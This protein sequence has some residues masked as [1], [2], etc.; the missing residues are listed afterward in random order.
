MKSHSI[1][2]VKVAKSIAAINRNDWDSVFP[3]I[4]ESYNFF[5]TI[6]ETM[7]HQFKPYYISIFKEERII[8]VAPCFIMDYPL[9]TTVEGRLKRVLARIRNIAPKL[10]QW[11]VLICGCTAAEGRIG[12]KDIIDQRIPQI[13]IKKMY[14]IARKEKARLIAFKD[15]SQEYSEFFAPLIKSGFHKMQSYP[16]VELNIRFRSFEDYLA[17]L[18]RITRKGLYRKFREVEEQVKIE[19]EVRPDLAEF[20]DKAYELYLNTLNKSKVQFERLSKEFFRR[21]SIN[22]PEEVKYFLWRING[23]LVAF[24]LCLVKGDVLVDEYIGLDYAVAYKY[25]LYYVT[26]RDILIWCI[27][28]GIRRYESGALNYDPK[29][30]LDFKFL[31]QYIY[32]KH[33]SFFMNLL[34][35]LLCLIIKPENFD[36]VLK[37]M[38]KSKE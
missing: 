1:F 7:L 24:D 11:R 17:S 22:M 31:P 5:K 28:H 14:S 19:M 15:F 10:L 30:R 3:S 23:E 38:E 18:S 13:L 6:D 16:S 29:K 35:G 9:E 37:A 2:T 4:P 33:K 21:I 32:V 26:F 36:P 20:L 34:I 12:I 8:A 27:D 25:H